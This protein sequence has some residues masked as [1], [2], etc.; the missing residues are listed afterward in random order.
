MTL[1]SRGLAR[2]SDKL[3]SLHLHYYNANGT[4]LGRMMVWLELGLPIKSHYYIITPS[5]EI[6][7]QIKVIIYVYIYIYVYIFIYTT[8][9]L[10]A[11]KLGRV[12]IYNEELYSIN[13]QNL[14]ITWSCKVMRNI[15]SVISLLQRGQCSQNL[16]SWW[17]TTRRSTHKFTQPSEHVVT[18]GHMIN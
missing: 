9:M 5:C 14:L 11:T 16:A 6:M 12:S 10:V 2:S 13:L 7:W 18:W 8:T 15:R 3:K 1:K 17:L 4:K